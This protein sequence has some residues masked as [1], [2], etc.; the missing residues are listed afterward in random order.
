MAARRASLIEVANGGTPQVTFVTDQFGN[1]K[2]GVRTPYVDVPSATY[3]VTGT[4]KPGYQYCSSFGTETLF[5]SGPQD[6]HRGRAPADPV[7]GTRD[8][9]SV[10][11]A[12][13]P[14]DGRFSRVT[15]R[16]DTPC[17]Y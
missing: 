2:G 4:L 14:S 1:A 6:R 3:S 9:K 15:H 11:R 16:K 5:G 8:Q 17:R 7:G 10:S 13:P 12:P